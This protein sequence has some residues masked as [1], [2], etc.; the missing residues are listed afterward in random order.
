MSIESIIRTLQEGDSVYTL[1]KYQLIMRVLNQNPPFVTTTTPFSEKVK[2]ISLPMVQTDYL[3]RTD[4]TVRYPEHIYRYTASEEQVLPYQLPRDDAPVYYTYVIDGY[5]MGFGRVLDSLEMGVAHQMIV[6]HEMDPV[7]IAGELMIQDNRLWFNFESGTFSKIKNLK[8]NPVLKHYL[9]DLVTLLFQ[10]YHRGDLGLDQVTYTDDILFP[11]QPFTSYELN[12]ICTADPTRI[13]R[14]ENRCKSGLLRELM[15]EE[16]NVC[17]NPKFEHEA[18][19]T[20]PMRSASF[21]SF[22]SS[23]TEPSRT[24]STTEPSRAISTTE[25]IDI[26]DESNGFLNRAKEH[27]E[28][29]P[30]YQLSKVYSTRN[31]KWYW[32]NDPANPFVFH[33]MGKKS[34]KKCRSYFDK[35]NV[36]FSKQSYK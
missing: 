19:R 24:S 26:S 13:F 15:T 14:V 33:A 1:D 34:K 17:L 29:L 9:M 6:R 4:Y 3:T 32:N 16:N 27:V 10:L 8:K 11:A 2:C 21:A 7:I 12:R 23:T 28:R 30:A 22:A 5:G 25:P 36:I 35:S 20:S 18:S 31:K